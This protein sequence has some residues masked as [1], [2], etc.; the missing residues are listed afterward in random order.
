[1]IQLISFLILIIATG[2]FIYITKYKNKEK[3]KVGIKREESLNYFKDYLN[4]KLYWVSIAFIVFGI[5]IL[6][7]IIILELLFN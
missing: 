3:P 4:L 1:M 5:T 2:V 7:A 6:L